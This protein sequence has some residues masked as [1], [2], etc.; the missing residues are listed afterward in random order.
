VYLAEHEG[1]GS[2]FT[3]KQR[4]FS[5]Y[6]IGGNRRLKILPETVY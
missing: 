1:I 4:D 2:I 5:V 3:L 6:R